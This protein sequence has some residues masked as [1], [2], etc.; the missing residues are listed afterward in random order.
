[1]PTNN[2]LQLRVSIE[3]EPMRQVD[4]VHQRGSV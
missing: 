4:A 3:S 1:M 2:E